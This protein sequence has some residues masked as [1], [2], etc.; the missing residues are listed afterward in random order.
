MA[1]KLADLRKRLEQ[2]NDAQLL[3]FIGRDADAKVRTVAYGVYYSRWAREPDYKYF[4]RG[5]AMA[6]AL[7]YMGGPKLARSRLT[8]W[9]VA[10]S[11]YVLRHPD[12]TLFVDQQSKDW[13]FRWRGPE[14]EDGPWVE[15]ELPH[16]DAGGEH[17]WWTFDLVTRVHVNED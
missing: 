3:W 10:A 5:E 15:L 8:P 1:T 11:L 17:A 6:A 4:D 14:T 16:H 9:M 13:V 2:L 12:Q 7:S